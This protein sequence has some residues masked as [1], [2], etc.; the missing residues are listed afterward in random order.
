M[1]LSTLVQDLKSDI[2]GS[3][4]SRDE[5]GGLLE[6]RVAL[7]DDFREGEAKMENTNYGNKCPAPLY[8]YWFLRLP[9]ELSMKFSQF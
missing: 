5:V 9:G 8:H 2:N 4:L 6:G 7:P 1:E 3:E